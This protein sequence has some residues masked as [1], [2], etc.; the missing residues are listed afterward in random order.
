[1]RECLDIDPGAATARLFLGLSLVEMGQAEAALRQLETALELSPSPEMSAALG[2][3]YTR[4]GRVDRAARA[5]HDAAAQALRHALRVALALRAGLLRIGRS[6]ERPR[7]AGEGA[8]R[9]GQQ[10]RLARSPVRSSTPSGRKPALRR[11]S[12]S[13]ATPAPQRSHQCVRSA[14]CDPAQNPR[15]RRAKSLTKGMIFAIDRGTHDRKPGKIRIEPLDRCGAPRTDLAPVWARPYTEA[16]C[17]GQERRHP[18]N[19]R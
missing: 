14:R 18:R 4:N 2:Y 9:P 19:G 8:A 10:S 1:M 13:F 6:R 12:R 5:R 7:L 3:A 15:T 11:C 17:C 16:P